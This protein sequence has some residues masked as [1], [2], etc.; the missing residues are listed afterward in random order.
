MT[1]A[2]RFVRALATATAAATVAMAGTLLAGATAASASAAPLRPAS[3]AS[4]TKTTATKKAKKTRIT[5]H[6]KSATISRY[7]GTPRATL[8]VKASGTKLRYSWQARRPSGSWQTIAGATKSSYQASAASWANGTGFRV[9]V[10]GSKGTVT[11][12]TAT[13]TVLMPSNTPAKDAAKAF[14]LAGLSQG[15]DLSSYQYTPS[16]KVR[17]GVLADWAGTNGFAIL[18]LGS[19]ARPIN[20]S[21]ADACTNESRNTGNT[22]VVQ[23]CAFAT[24]SDQVRAAGMRQGAYWFNGWTTGVDTSP[25]NLFAGDFTP[26]KSAARFVA[27]LKADGNYTKTS[28]NPLVIDVEAGGSFSKSSG[29]KKYTH[30]LRAWTPAEAAEFLTTAKA[31]LTAD[32]YRANLYV[33]LS[34]SVAEQKTKGRY[35]WSDVAG[36]A[37]L[38]VASWGANNARVPASQPKVGPWSTRGGWSIWQYTSNLRISGS[39][40]DAL[41]GD[42][43][44]PDA[45][46]PR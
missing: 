26:A 34:A 35:A 23:D 16:A 11:S 41:D 19:G 30:A 45:W 18:R 40:V 3:A 12:T 29:G 31:L 32:G 5:S 17:A 24:L 13:L 2:A 27:I 10:K 21:Y 14:G 22:P 7:G 42:L 25:G 44:K 6:P 20:H 1:A 8:K 37:R 36:I 33:Y 39:G 38:W 15:V 43:A 46:T 28:T 4:A 9:K